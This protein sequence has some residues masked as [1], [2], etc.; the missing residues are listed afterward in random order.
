MP[1][2]KYFPHNEQDIK[3][4]LKRIGVEKIEDLFTDIPQNILTKK[5]YLLIKDCLR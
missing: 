5:N 2:Y 4:M 1:M 3:E